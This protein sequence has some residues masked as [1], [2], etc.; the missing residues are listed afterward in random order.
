ML[1]RKEGVDLNSVQTIYVFPWLM[2]HDLTEQISKLRKKKWDN[3]QGLVDC[4]TLYLSTASGSCPSC[5][6]ISLLGRGSYNTVY[7]LV[8]NDDTQLAAC[9]SNHDEEDFNVQAKQSEIETMKFVRESGLYPDIPVPSVM[10]GT[11][12]LIILSVHP[13]SSWIL[14]KGKIWMT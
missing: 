14:F 4:S 5:L 1:A 11:L 7:R 9:V 6:S 3:L 10:H 12:H 8:F 13:I 2:H